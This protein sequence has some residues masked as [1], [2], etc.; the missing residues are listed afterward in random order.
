MGLFFLRYLLLAFRDICGEIATTVILRGSFFRTDRGKP[1]TIF[2][3]DAIMETVLF[4]DGLMKK[5]FIVVGIIFIFLGLYVYTS[6]RVW[7]ESR[8]ARNITIHV[9]KLDGTAISNTTIGLESVN[10]R[11][12]VQNQTGPDGKIFFSRLTPGMYKILAPQMGCIEENRI[13]QVTIQGSEI[14][15]RYYPCFIAV[16]R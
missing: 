13:P 6:Y 5:V 11:F 3:I 15:I 12:A 2:L 1:L 4:G 16:R 7:E 10:E 14:Y 8:M 9:L